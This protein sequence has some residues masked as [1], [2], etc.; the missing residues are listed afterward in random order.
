MSR[1]LARRS[2]ASLI[3]VPLLVSCSGHETSRS[4]ATAPSDQP[5]SSWTSVTATTSGVDLGST[6]DVPEGWRLVD[7]DEILPMVD[8]MEAAAGDNEVMARS[9]GE[10]RKVLDDESTLGVLT[11]EVSGFSTTLLIAR[12]D[13]RESLAA[14]TAR[15]SSRL[16][17][18]MAGLGGKTG[19]PVPVELG[20]GAGARIVT[21]LSD[22]ELPAIASQTVLVLAVADGHTY[23]L[24][25]T[26]P[27]EADWFPEFVTE[28]GRR[29]RAAD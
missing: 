29:W 11:G 26:A 24:W 10:F 15:Q 3:V 14:A 17:R 28:I 19:R 21:S 4:D 16:E 8:A 12:D 18:L 5:P 23:S 7:P 13:M 2:V 1:R 9:S 22:V 20:F 6:I 27:L 25:G